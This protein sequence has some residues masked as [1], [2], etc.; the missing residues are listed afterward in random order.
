M[1]NKIVQHPSTPEDLKHPETPADELLAEMCPLMI[2][3]IHDWGFNIQEETFQ[4]D[5]RIVVEILRA[6]LYGQLGVEHELQVGLGLNNPLTKLDDI[7]ASEGER[8]VEFT[9]DPTLTED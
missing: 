9:P 7:I 4:Q 3:M 6:V 2:D 5:F 1:N 8:V